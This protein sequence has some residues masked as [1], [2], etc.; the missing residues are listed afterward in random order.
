MTDLEIT[1]HCA[2][3]MG[4]HTGRLAS[5]V[6]AY[7]VRDCAIIAGNDHGGESV[8]DPLHDDAQAM[9]LVKK[10]KPMI[11]TYFDGTWVVG[12]GWHGA[13]QIENTDLNRAICECVAKLQAA[14]SAT[15][16]DRA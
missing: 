8:Y 4:W 13:V 15:A 7:S 14:K 16:S 3:A 10:F 11:D 9:A 2:E 5:K 12:S 1:R 6:V